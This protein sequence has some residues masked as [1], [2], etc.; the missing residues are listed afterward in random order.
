M[1]RNNKISI[2]VF[3]KRPKKSHGGFWA[4]TCTDPL[5]PEQSL[6]PQRGNGEVAPGP[7]GRH[8]KPPR[9][10]VA[11]R[12]HCTPPTEQD[13]LC[14][15]SSLQLPST[16]RTR[17]G[18]VTERLARLRVSGAWFVLIFSSINGVKDGTHLTEEM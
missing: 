8:T 7:R 10:V 4:L 6:L 9:L 17:D 1:G 14:D 13:S 12:E 16:L 15:R 11:R 5:G 2:T 18:T 3:K